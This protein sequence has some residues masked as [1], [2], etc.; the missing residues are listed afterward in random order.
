LLAAQA[1]FDLLDEGVGKRSRLEGLCESLGSPLGL[2][3]VTLKAL[4]GFAAA[5]LGSF[6]LALLIGF[7]PGHGA[8]LV[9]EVVE[10]DGRVHHD[11]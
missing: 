4:M 10:R 8:F 6:G 2:G 9:I 1:S 5:V 3:P 11:L 7:G